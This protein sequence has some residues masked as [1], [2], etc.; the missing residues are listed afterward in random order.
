[1]WNMARPSL[2]SYSPNIPNWKGLDFTWYI[3]LANGT[4]LLIFSQ[5]LPKCFMQGSLILKYSTSFCVYFIDRAVIMPRSI[6]LILDHQCNTWINFPLWN[7]F[8]SIKQIHGKIK[9]QHS[10]IKI[11]VTTDWHNVSCPSST[12]TMPTNLYVTSYN[13]HNDPIM[14]FTIST[15]R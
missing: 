6:K 12:I 4:S 13:L 10:P 9:I 14:C 2:H 5:C 7:I 15:E 3:E 8:P 11:M 1:M